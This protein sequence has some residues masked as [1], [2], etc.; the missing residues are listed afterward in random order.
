MTI[1]LQANRLG[2]PVRG[3]LTQI[4]GSDRH[5]RYYMDEAGNTFILYRGILTIV[6]ADGKV[7]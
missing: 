3:Q 4:E 5:C 1:F 2:V 7:I 6:T